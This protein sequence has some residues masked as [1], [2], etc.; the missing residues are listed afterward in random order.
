MT[1]LNEVHDILAEGLGYQKAP[2]LEE[3]PQCPC[4]GSYITG[5]H[6][7]ATLAA[8]AARKL[9]RRQNHIQALGRA[10]ERANELVAQLTVNKRAAVDQITE[11]QEELAV[12]RRQCSC[13]YWALGDKIMPSPDCPAHGIDAL[14]TQTAVS[15]ITELQQELVRQQDHTQVISR[16][17][18]RVRSDNTQLEQQL[19]LAQDRIRD[20][21]RAREV[22]V[23]T[24]TRQIIDLQCELAEARKSKPKKRELEEIID[25]KNRELAERMLRCCC[26]FQDEGID[27]G[28]LLP[29]P[30]CEE[31]GVEANDRRLAGT[32]ALNTLAYVRKYFMGSEHG[33]EV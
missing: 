25:K 10:L 12:R 29:H 31:H 2:T 13:S 16:S 15:Q 32:K 19:E 26:V 20:I 18:D 5:D 6:T 11:L 14:D 24:A 27:E 8:E 23:E 21:Q 17:V 3:D 4:P 33:H 1:E 7:A 28:R 30:D 9:A 22:A